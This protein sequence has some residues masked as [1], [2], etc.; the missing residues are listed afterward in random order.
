MAFLA[1]ATPWL[2]R[3]QFPVNKFSDNYTKGQNKTSLISLLYR[4]KKYQYIFYKHVLL[5]GLNVSVALDLQKVSSL[6]LV[7][8]SYEY[9]YREFVVLIDY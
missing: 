3:D 7:L 9:I 8:H 5:H 2:V 6:L 4:A 1:S